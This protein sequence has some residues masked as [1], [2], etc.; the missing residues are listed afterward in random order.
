M[1]E[2]TGNHLQN[3]DDSIIKQQQFAD[4]RISEL[5]DNLVSKNKV[6]VYLSF[7]LDVVLC[8]LVLCCLMLSYVVAAAAAAAILVVVAAAVLVL[9]S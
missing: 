7:L 6:L 4:K 3:I 5:E 1:L 9:F 8:C 2:Q